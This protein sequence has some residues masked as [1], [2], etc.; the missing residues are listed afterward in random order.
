MVRLDIIE[1]E[2]GK[3][4][5]TKKRVERQ[6]TIAVRRKIKESKYVTKKDS[7]DKRII[8]IQHK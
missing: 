1:K 2:K 8:D 6:I 3:G 4:E 5:L 7:K